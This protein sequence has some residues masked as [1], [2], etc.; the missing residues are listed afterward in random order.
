MKCPFDENLPPAPK[1]IS[2]ELSPL[3]APPPSAR[4]LIKTYLYT[5]VVKRLPLIPLWRRDSKNSRRRA[6]KT[7]VFRALKNGLFGRPDGPDNCDSGPRSST[8]R[9]FYMINFD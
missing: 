1:H 8:Q 2:L 4:A 3:R 6:P 5:R 7:H 9:S